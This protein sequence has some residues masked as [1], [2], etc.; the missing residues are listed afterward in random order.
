MHRILG[1][2]TGTNS[3][4]WAIVEK[5]PDGYRLLDKGVNIFQEGVKIE[6]GIESSKAAERTGYRVIRKSYYRRKLRKI[7]LLRVL[8]DNNMCP[9]LTS[10]Q[11]SSWRLKKVYPI[12]ELF[13]QWQR[14]DDN[15]GVN[16]YAYRHKCLHERLDLTNATHRYILGRA[17]YHLNQRR[18]FLSNRKDQTS[19]EESGAVKGA[20][21][22][23][24]K[25][26]EAV[27]CD[28]LG[29][30]FFKLY[31]DGKKIRKHYTA[32]NEHYL[33]EFNAICEKQGLDDALV[34]KLRKAIFYQRPLKSQKGMVGKCPFEPKKSKCPSSHPRFEEY[35]MLCFLNNVKFK[36]PYDE[37]PRPLTKEEREKVM[38]K[39]YR[40]S[41]DSFLFEDIAKEL[42][43]KG[44]Y[45][46]IKNTDDGYKDYFF[47]YP[48]DTP[49]SGC[50]VTARLKDIFGNDWET[51]ICEIYTLGEGKSMAQI[52]N[53]VWHA[54]YFSSDDDHL[55]DFARRR[56]QL[57]D[58]NVKKFCD[59]R[60]PSVYAQLSLK[61]INKILPYLRRGYIYSHSVLMANMEEVLPSEVWQNP[62]YREA[63]IEMVAELC[64]SHEERR[65]DTY[66]HSRDVEEGRETL[67]QKIGTF[68][69]ERY[70]VAPKSL[71][72][73][74]HPSNLD[75]YPRVRRNDNGIYQLGSPR[76]D[77]VRNP[78]A[79]RSLFRLRRL[80][81]RLL[82]KGLIDEDT[83]VHIEFA[84]ELNDANKRKA[85]KN[86]NKD[87]RKRREDAIKEIKELYKKETNKNIE[88]NE[89]EVLKYLLWEEQD[90][91]CIYTGNTIGI[92]D[93]IGAEP[94]YDIEHTIPQSIGGDSTME[95]LTLCESRFNRDV[96]RAK[97]PSELHGQYPDI[98][99]R[100][101]PWK[102]KFEKLDAGIRKNRMRCKGASTKEAKDNLLV[103]RRKLEMERNYWRGKYQRFTMTSVPQDFSRR[104]GA[105]IGV[106]SKY[107]RLYLR[108]VFRHV[109]T[110][111]GLATSD[112]RK[113]WGIQDEYTKK[114]RVNHVHHC[115]DAIVIACIGL[116]EYGKLAAYYHSEEEYRWCHASK[117]HFP[118]PWQTFV[119]D[120]K[121]VQNEILVYHYTA[122]NVSKHACR[123]LKNEKS[124][125]NVARKV[126]SKMNVARGALHK[127][128][129]YGAI[130]RDGEDV[131]YVKRVSLDMLSPADVKNIVDDTVRGIIEA[132]I[133]EKGFKRAM[134]EPIWM[135]EEKRIPIKKVRCFSPSVTNPLHIRS[136]RDASTK[137]YKQQFHV[138][139]DTNYL[140][141]LYIGK[142]AKGK[143]RRDFELVNLLQATRHYCARRESTMANGL[144]PEKSKHGYPL[145]YTL[146]VGTLVLLYENKAEE[147]WES[148][149]EE[150]SHRLY[151]I[152]GL[153]SFV[154]GVNSYG[155]VLMR[156][157]EEARPAADIKPKDGAYKQGEAYRSSIKMLHTQIK[158][159]VQGVDF[160]ID[161]T[162]QI[163]NLCCQ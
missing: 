49:V 124:D 152:S 59:I 157:H 33:K 25:E 6:K 63:A 81:N 44:Q 1:I 91:H 144:V 108:S 7:R 82:Q 143:E 131:R 109:Y 160:E 28:Y 13:I 121:R 125:D 114:E 132:A 94:K 112:F 80:V 134:A 47:N 9:P 158:A 5:L 12:D 129:Y 138:A 88:P 75:V 46:Y 106:I 115:L 142:D 105:D 36:T 29:D 78:M 16:P 70:N 156:H 3:L 95:N 21:S 126:Y 53:D 127:E 83:E 61:A 136:Q 162:G 141:A 122:D 14:T 66:Y 37:E 22:S 67:E 55:A 154:S 54:L 43:P 76:I 100:I 98:L 151:K 30:Y 26:M 23:L 32:R 45:G 8:C 128:T 86:M 51:G 56:L 102:E 116:D 130:K 89:A 57:D 39:F 52:V 84:R 24:S 103:E 159:L 77:S 119:E 111:K 163:R 40:K 150:L 140:M 71:K 62:D 19:D 64:M 93:F 74:Y 31:Q 69:I 96:K 65:D 11:L 139:N 87:N 161:E 97:I 120:L 48:M 118:K 79:M 92:T 155:R 50:P 10:S 15:K 145:A 20:I 148:S 153:S 107:A 34:E 104:Q 42:A 147:V 4:G 38:P 99:Q 17:L 41:K 73:L 68:L 35:R 137:D 90:H 72:Q 110:V 149:K 2:D 135:N 27:G 117:P 58:H 101:A 113:L 133:R 146:K 18:G 85:I 123:F 60:L